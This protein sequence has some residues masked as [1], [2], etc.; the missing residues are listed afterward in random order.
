MRYKIGYFRLFFVSKLVSGTFSPINKNAAI[1]IW[2]Y[3][4]HK[5]AIM[6]H[7]PHKILFY[8]PFFCSFFLR[9]YSTSPK[10][11]TP[12]NQDF[13][14]FPKTT[15]PKNQDFHQ[16]WLHMRVM[17]LGEVLYLQQFVNSESSI[18]WMLKVA[19]GSALFS[20]TNC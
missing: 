13:C 16:K 17:I 9:I 15:S 5:G 8:G 10:I 20:V 14:L 6:S 11:R 2:T 7:Q 19:N 18:S 1:V 3:F 4:C 12:K